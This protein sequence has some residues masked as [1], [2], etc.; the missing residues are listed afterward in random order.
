LSGVQHALDLRAEEAL[1]HHLP[2]SEL[3]ARI[4]RDEVDRRDGEQLD[5]R[6]RL[7]APFESPAPAPSLWPRAPPCSFLLAFRGRHDVGPT[8]AGKGHLAQ[9]LGQRACRLDRSVVFVSAQ[10]LFHGPHA[11]RGDGTFD[12]KLQRLVDPDLLINDNRG[13]RPLRGEEPDDPHELVGGRH[14]HHST[15]LTSNRAIP[16]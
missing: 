6:V 8:S 2:P 7:P 1:E 14:E 12:R 3:R 4:L 15:V 10:G 16:E 11:A 13:L 5:L 9:A